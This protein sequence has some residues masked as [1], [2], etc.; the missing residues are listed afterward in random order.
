MPAKHKFNIKEIQQKYNIDER[1][2]NHVQYIK[3]IP[4]KEI[5][6]EYQKIKSDLYL[7]QT[8]LL[9]RMNEVLKI[10]HSLRSRVKEEEHLIEKIIRKVVSKPDKYDGINEDNYYKLVTD[11]LGFRII[12]LNQNDWEQVHE[13][14]LAIF[15]NNPADYIKEHEN[16][17]EYYD[18]HNV[19]ANLK[20]GFLV[21]QPIVYITS[22]AERAFYSRDTLRVDSSK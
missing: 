8:N 3:N 2:L 12:I 21:E 18:R 16:F 10:S 5:Y 4:L 17:A 19:N 11:L 6:D 13:M 7:I 15:D 22:E 14:I 1:T 20:R 9:A